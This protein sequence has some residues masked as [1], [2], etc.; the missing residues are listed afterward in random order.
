MQEKLATLI[1]FST[2]TC[3][4]LIV[5][6][7][8][9]STPRPIFLPG[10]STFTPLLVNFAALPD[11]ASALLEDP[12][13][14][15]L[16]IYGCS[17]AAYDCVYLFANAGK[18][19]TWIMRASGHG[20]VWMAPA[21]INLGPFRCWLEKLVTTRF[22]TLFSPCVWGD[23]DG[24]GAVRSMLHGTRWGR[25]VVDKFWET[26]S[27]DTIKQS[28]LLT[29]DETGELKKLIPDENAFWYASGLGILNYPSDV[30]DFVRSGQVKIVRKDIEGLMGRTVRLAG[31]EVVETDAM[32]CSTGWKWTCGVNFLPESAHADLG[33]PSTSYSKEQTESWSQLD[34]KADLE[35]FRRFPKL[36]SQPK[37]AR[38]LEQETNVEA[39][40][41]GKREQYTSWR[42]WR[43]MVPPTLEDRS[44][45]F[46]G[47][48]MNIQTAI[49]AEVSSLWAYAY[50]N[51]QLEE[52]PRKL[53][54]RYN[55]SESNGLSVFG[56][57]RTLLRGVKRLWGSVWGGERP[58]SQGIHTTH[59]N[60]NMKTYDTKSL[61]EDLRYE[62]ALFNRFGRWRCPS[63]YGAKFP[64]FAFDG[65]PYYDLLLGDLGVRSWRK[66][67]GWVGE[68]FGGGYGPED[69]R[70]VV[71]EWIRKRDRRG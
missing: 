69:Y 41:E 35:I 54:A 15:H 40:K 65:V 28:G 43:G 64:D 36:A 31:G 23:A 21:F 48:V 25:W 60:A 11:H 29:R 38:Y 58:V 53:S 50:M 63:G 17:K 66:G 2:I 46:L 71:E 8:L 13:I 10:R 30:Y 16:T 32:I 59:L 4:K 56:K 7:G 52:R 24:F 57:A 34:R 26:L 47:M 49:R 39:A 1:A 27:G 6:T 37:S 5:A 9:T 12:T 14:T 33:V 55:L 45:V 18:R 19:I 70:G 22:F 61:M 51:G 62:T 44:L 42:L 67:W 20:A 68:V 3:S